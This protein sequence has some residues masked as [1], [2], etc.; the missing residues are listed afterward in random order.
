VCLYALSV[1]Y[2]TRL[3]PDIGLQCAFSLEVI[4]VDA[5]QLRRNADEPLPRIKDRIVRIGEQKI[6]TWPQILIELGK[7]RDQPKD[8]DNR[9]HTFLNG[10][11]VLL[12]ELERP[13]DRERP[14]TT[15]WCVLDRAPLDSLLPSIL[16]FFLKLGLFVVGFLVFWQR[17]A[18]RSAAAFFCLCAVTVGAYMGGYHWVRIVPRPLLL[19]VFIICAVLPIWSFLGPRTFSCAGRAGHCLP[20][21]AFL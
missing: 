18:D 14:F 17:P 4:R 15:V 11:E 6:S 7:L 9:T 21:T 12:V 16:W 19:V 2:A 13:G 1:L 3:I 5:R 8:S 10:E 20:H